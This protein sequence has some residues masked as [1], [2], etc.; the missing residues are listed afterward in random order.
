[1]IASTPLLAFST[2]TMANTTA[3]APSGMNMGSF[4][5]GMQAIGAITGAIG[6]F[7]SAKSAREQLLLQSNI[8]RINA[9]MAENTAQSALYAGQAEVGRQTLRAGQL[10]SAQRASLAANGVDLGVG[11]AAETLAST[12]VMKDIDKNTIEQN[13]IGS[14]WG[15]R[16]QASNYMIDAAAKS[17]TRDAISPAGSAAT[18]LMGSAGQVASSWYQYKK[19]GG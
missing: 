19:A 15:Y 18:S 11:S 12:D 7:Y 10:K 2:P 8:S 17:M 9:Q 3:T 1:M 5:V 13:A 16:T 4:G 6:S 14:A